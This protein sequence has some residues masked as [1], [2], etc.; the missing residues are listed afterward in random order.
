MRS[1]AGI[2]R[3]KANGTV[4][5]M[6]PRPGPGRSCS[7]SRNLDRALLHDGWTLLAA[8][9]ATP[10]LLAD[11]EQGVIVEGKLTCCRH[12]CGWQRVINWQRS[13]GT[14]TLAGS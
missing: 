13:S 14:L 11:I 12:A 4:N 7:P 8:D 3:R 9:D 5:S 10:E 6:T 2:S 1:D